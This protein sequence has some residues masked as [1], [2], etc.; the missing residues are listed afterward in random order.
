MQIECIQKLAK[1]FLLF[2]SASRA[3][4][5]LIKG[6]SSDMLDDLMITEGPFKEFRG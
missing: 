1:R 6:A 2:S 3:A 5:S 4:T